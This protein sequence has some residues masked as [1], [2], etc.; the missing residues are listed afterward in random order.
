MTDPLSFLVERIEAVKALL[1]RIQTDLQDGLDVSGEWQQGHAARLVD[2]QATVATLDRTLRGDDPLSTLSRRAGLDT[3]DEDI[4]LLALAPTLDRSVSRQLAT[5]RRAYGAGQPDIDLT[6]GL[7][8]SGLRE[9]LGL[10]KRFD[11]DSP[12]LRA[13]LISLSR[14][15]QNSDLLAMEIHVPERVQRQLLAAAS[16]SHSAP[17]EH[18]PTTPRR[19]FDDVLM[20]EENLGRLRDVLDA[21][22]QRPG[23]RAGADIV[24]LTGPSGTGKTVTAEACA[25]HMGRPLLR[26]DSHALGTRVVDLPAAITDI[27]LES[28]LTGALLFFDDCELLFA[29]RLQGNRHL[30]M[31]LSCLDDALDIVLVA[32]QTE[33]VLDP[34]LRRRI[35]LRLA[36]EIPPPSLRTPL[37]RR[38]LPSMPLSDDV[39]VPFLAEKYEFNGAQIEMAS[40]LAAAS[41]IARTRAPDPD[42]LLLTQTDL[43][44]A[45]QAQLQNHLAQ[46]AV[47]TITHLAL[48]DLVLP[49]DLMAIIHSIIAAVR[50]RRRI[51]DDWGFGERM[52]TGKGLS[53]LFRG[54]SGT[55][56]TL[57]AEILGAELAIPL[58]RVSIPRIIS[59]YIGETEQNLE[60]AFHE[61]QLA[62]AILFFD[63]ADAIFTKRV[64]VSSS[65]DRYSNMEVN[66]LLQEMERFEGVVILT[67]NLDAAIDDAFDRRLN[68]KLDF[69]FPDAPLRRQIWSRLLPDKAPIV[70]TDDELDYLADQFELAGGSIKN[71]IIRAAYTA[72]EH[73]QTIDIDKLEA[74]C[75]QEYRELGKLVRS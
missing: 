36:L 49:V 8:T 23:R 75:I 31:L 45:A 15:R 73:S 22:I 47:R 60:K 50:N 28:R 3:T 6:L 20:P 5:L 71:V 41:A 30:P 38:A 74:A 18:H 27:L 40:H 56:K 29:S 33:E 32:T 64:E 55:G 53:M 1:T 52:T 25:S 67:T 39:D 62:G 12:L 42:P 17:G 37:W 66:L 14:P 46:L 9:R 61:A 70:V 63:E 34:S 57:T 44:S 21:H 35:L 48:K 68:F 69:P 10:I 51:F 58:Y 65:T 7:L 72:A 54:E 26:I 59:K 19:T 43:E 2:Y 13:G 4:L 16:T 11:P 24:L